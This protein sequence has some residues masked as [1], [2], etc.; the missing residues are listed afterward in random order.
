MLC[1]QLIMSHVQPSLV[2]THCFMPTV[3]TINRRDVFVCHRELCNNADTYLGQ[4]DF[5]CFSNIAIRYS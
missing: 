2:K 3:I 4:I 5:P 1:F